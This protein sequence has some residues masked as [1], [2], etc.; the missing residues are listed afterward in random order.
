MIATILDIETTGFLSFDTRMVPN[1]RGF[2]DPIEQ[3]VLSDRCEILEVGFI[4]IDIESAAMVNH[5]TL[6]FYKPYFQVESDAQRIHGLTREFLQQ[7]E[8][9]FEN[10]LIALNTLMQNAIIIGKNS[11]T[12]DIPVIKAFIEKHGGRPL[13]IQ[14]TVGLLNMKAYHSGYVIYENSTYSL[15]MQKFYKERFHKLYA[16]KYSMPIKPYMTDEEINAALRERFPNADVQYYN[17]CAQTR[18]Q[19]EAMNMTL[20]A[21]PDALHPKLKSTKKGSLEQYIDVIPGAQK[22]V[23]YLYSTLK[24]KREGSYHNALYDAVMTYVVWYDAKINGVFAEGNKNEA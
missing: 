15:D 23:D 12:F 2:G 14:T 22:V 11:Q 17:V 20:I 19:A 24:H 16:E 1:P 10:N 13:D 9:D 6:Y 7:Y 3:S 21:Y 4:N 18:Q 5:G 8:G